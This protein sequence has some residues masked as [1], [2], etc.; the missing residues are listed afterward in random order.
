[1]SPLPARRSPEGA[2]GLVEQGQVL[3]ALHQKSPEGVVEV[4]AT[5]DLDE[6]EHA[7]LPPS[8][9]RDRQT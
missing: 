5:A 7:P 1:M 4:F 6:F 2:K 8:A 9:P 3:D